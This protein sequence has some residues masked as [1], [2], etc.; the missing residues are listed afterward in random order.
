M[1]MNMTDKK[2]SKGP[3]NFYRTG[4]DASR[5][6][7]A[8]KSISTVHRF[9]MLMLLEGHKIKD[10]AEA[11]GMTTDRIAIIRNSPLFQQEYKRLEQLF[12]EKY[13]EKVVDIRTQ[14]ESTQTLAL[15][16]LKTLMTDEQSPR[17]IKRAAARDILSIG[18]KYLNAKNNI[19]K[20]TPIAELIKM[21]YEAAMRKRR[22]ETSIPAQA[23]DVVDV[24][25][26]ADANANANNDVDADAY[27][28]ANADVD[29]NADVE[30]ESAPTKSLD[31]EADDPADVEMF[32]TKS[33]NVAEFSS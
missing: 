28:D 33:V 26:D 22:Q 15:Q 25:V 1:A 3:Q 12:T 30:A 7:S 8:L 19:D 13:V 29:V 6:P 17:A 27:A 24:D 9:I 23:V 5:E 32:G 21:G 4:G 20:E 10:I 14:L 16:T 11:V 2:G 18:E 31:V